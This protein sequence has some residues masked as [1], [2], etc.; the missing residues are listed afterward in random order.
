MKIKDIMTRDVE[1]IRPNDT[2]RSVAQKM[3][4][5]DVGFLPVFEGDQLVGVITDRDLVVR[6]LAEGINSNWILGHELVTSPVI[7]C[8]ED[9]EVEDAARLMHLNRIRRLIILKR[10]DQSLAGV[11]SLADLV[12]MVDDGLTSKILQGVSEPVTSY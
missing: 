7:H 6:V 11:V 9:Q 3:R 5:R 8:F 1:F 10:S 4:K 2:I 12:G